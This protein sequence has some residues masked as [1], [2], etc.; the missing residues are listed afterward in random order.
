[1]RRLEAFHEENIDRRLPLREAM[2]SLL[3]DMYEH[4]P[5]AL[6]PAIDEYAL[7]HANEC[8]LTKRA[9][10]ETGH[11]LLQLVLE[12]PVYEKSVTRLIQLLMRFSLPS[13]RPAIFPGTLTGLC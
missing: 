1:M 13:E 12:H 7:L 2:A 9:D 10:D 5:S 8:A 6:H 11:A 4:F 3:V